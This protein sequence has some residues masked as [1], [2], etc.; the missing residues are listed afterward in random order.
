MGSLPEH[1]HGAGC[2]CYQ[3][4]PACPH[5][6]HP[7][8]TPSAPSTAPVQGSSGGAGK[9]IGMGIG[10]SVFLLTVALSA[11]AVAISTVALTICVLILRSVWQDLRK[12]R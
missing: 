2:G 8:L 4:P 11:V 10:G 7:P 1:Q 6:H 5:P 12:G 9:W 3:P